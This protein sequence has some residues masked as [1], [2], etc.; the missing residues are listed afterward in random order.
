[1]MGESDTGLDV[2]LANV[3]GTSLKL[4]R[5]DNSCPDSPAG[6]LAQINAGCASCFA[7]SPENQSVERRHRLGDAVASIACGRGCCLTRPN[8]GKTVDMIGNRRL[9]FAHVS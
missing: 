4:Q 3:L 1:M 6:S 5:H 9:L 2:A 8:D 7:V